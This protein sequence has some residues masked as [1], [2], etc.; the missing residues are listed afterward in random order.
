ML[1]DA[2]PNCGARIGLS[3]PHAEKTMTRWNLR[4][5][6]HLSCPACGAPLQYVRSRAETAAELVGSLGLFCASAGAI[7]RQLSLEG[8]P[9]WALVLALYGIAIVA[10]AIRLVQHVRRQHYVLAVAA[11]QGQ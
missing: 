10:Y 4:M 2:C 8:G 3:G 6:V 9:P 5:L 7:W 1:K 11:D